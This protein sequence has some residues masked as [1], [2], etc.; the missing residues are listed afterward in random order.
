MSISVAMCT[1][2]GEQYVRD[3]LDSIASQ[4]RPPDEVVVIDDSSTDDTL[5][6]VRQWASEV[7]FPVRLHVNHP[8]LGSIKNFERAMSLCQGDIIALSD[9]DDVW[10]PEKLARE[11][12]LL[13]DRP[14]VGLVF[15]DAEVVDNELRPLG[16]RM[17]Q[18][19]RFSEKEQRLMR[20]GRALEVLLRRNVVMGATM[21][22]RSAFR[23][24]VLPIPQSKFDLHDYWITFLIAA[25]ADIA[26]IPT[27]LV[28]YRQSHEQQVGAHRPT[29]LRMLQDK[30]GR[31][32]RARNDERYRASTVWL[33][34]VQHRLAIPEQRGRAPGNLNWQ[35]ESKIKHLR[36]RAELP[37]ERWKRVPIIAAD[38]MTLRYHRYSV[39]I[40][41]AMR[42]L[43]A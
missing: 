8:N 10:Y 41:D 7:D 24:L 28:K 16:Y 15:A 9:Q 17:W 30:L 12:E 11:A 20:E 31:N 18:S 39:G 33:E 34:Q 36:K 3:Q 40:W 23:P 26:F 6:L 37:A 19:C 21:A 42:D 43:S 25:V 22:F 32:N 5:R 14:E 38:L 1:Y 2:N 29:G 13:D 35:I 4:T 27:P